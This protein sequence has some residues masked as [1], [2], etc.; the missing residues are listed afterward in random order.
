MNYAAVIHKDADSAYGVIVPDIPGCYSSGETFDEAIQSVKEAIY[1]HLEILLEEGQ[2]I[3]TKPSKIEDLINNPDYKDGIWALV[4]IDMTKL[5]TKPERI[6]ISL[7]KFVLS[8]I[9]DF[10]GAR[11]ETRSGFLAR[12]A[13][14][15]IDEETTNKVAVA[16]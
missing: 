8:R 12:A 6:N 10:I 9:D 2:Q 1:A 11:H 7:P 15:A 5:D 16:A 3:V 13:L 14:N 4:D